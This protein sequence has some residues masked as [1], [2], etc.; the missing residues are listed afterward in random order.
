MTTMQEHKRLAEERLS[1]AASILGHREGRNPF[2]VLGEVQDALNGSTIE[3]ILER[4]EQANR[5]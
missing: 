5:G 3:Q 2:R 4:R 1:L